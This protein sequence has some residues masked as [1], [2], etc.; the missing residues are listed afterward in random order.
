MG[1]VVVGHGLSCPLAG[2]IFLD[3]EWNP[4]RLYRQADSY[5]LHHQGSPLKIIWNWQIEG[6]T[7]SGLRLEYTSYPDFLH[8]SEVIETCRLQAQYHLAWQTYYFKQRIKNKQ[9]RVRELLCQ[10][11]SVWKHFQSFLEQFCGW[12]CHE[13]TEKTFGS[14]VSGQPFLEL[15]YRS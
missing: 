5:P 10:H 7:D 12:G 6:W 9:K 13:H 14:P 4:C 15:K 11:S 2:G 8:F 1:S 3:Q